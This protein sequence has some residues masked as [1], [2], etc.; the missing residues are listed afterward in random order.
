MTEQKTKEE[1]SYRKDTYTPQVM[2]GR[3]K[4]AGK[5]EK[6][7]GVGLELEGTDAVSERNEGKEPRVV[8]LRAQR[9]G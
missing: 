8:G 2:I 7:L 5:V 9:R 4:S 6:K 3:T 1:T